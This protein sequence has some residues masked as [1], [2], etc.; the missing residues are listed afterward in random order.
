[1]RTSS[2]ALLLLLA[3]CSQEA[4][5]DAPAAP[6]E[7]DNL[8]ECA[9]RGAAD[10]ARECTVE[11]AVANGIPILVVRHPDGGF[12]R[13]ELVDGSIATADGVEAAELATRG[14]EL[15]VRVGADRYRLPAG[16][17]GNEPQ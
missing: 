6:A 15:E 3:A 2:A 12:R 13:F 1:M 14:D 7:A 5:E 8:I 9:I 16:A 11:R 4:A 10:F 17:L